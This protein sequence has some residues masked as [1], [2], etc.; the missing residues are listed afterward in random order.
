MLRLLQSDEGTISVLIVSQ[1][2]GDHEVGRPMVHQSAAPRVFRREQ[3]GQLAKGDRGRLS[4]ERAPVSMDL[5]R[6]IANR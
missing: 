5:E 4:D 1:I 3:D 2:P 6:P